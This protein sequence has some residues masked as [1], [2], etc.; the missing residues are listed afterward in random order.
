MMQEKE[1]LNFL[2]DKEEILGELID[3]HVMEEV[4]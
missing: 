1:V 2:S 3:A 4:S